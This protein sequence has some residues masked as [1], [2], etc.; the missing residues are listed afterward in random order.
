MWFLLT[1]ISLLGV[2]ILVAL[3][4]ILKKLAT[5]SLPPIVV[6]NEQD[7]DIEESVRGGMK[8]AIKELE[9]EKEEQELLMRGLDKKPAMGVFNT[10][11]LEDPIDTKGYLIAA[12]LTEEEKELLRMFY[13]D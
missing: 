1:V 12:N 10:A 11:N 5:L 13:N 2:G 4:L 6:K 3:I 9:H 7:L 8:R